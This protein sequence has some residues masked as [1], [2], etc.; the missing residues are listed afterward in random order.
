MKRRALVFG[1]LALLVLAPA[2][3]WLYR[4]AYLPR[5]RAEF[6]PWMRRLGEWRD[7]VETT[8][9]ALKRRD[10]SPDDPEGVVVVRQWAWSGLDRIAYV[11]YEVRRPTHEI[12]KSTD[13]T[14]GLVY[15]TVGGFRAD[16]ARIERSAA[17]TVTTGSPPTARLTR[18]MTESIERRPRFR[19]A[20]AVAGLGAGRRDP[21]QTG[22][23]RLIAG[24]WPGSGVAV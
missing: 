7:A 12:G 3:V 9:R 8:R 16:G 17:A 19:N 23:N 24:I 22:T 15:F 18:V 5:L 4:N 10:A 14:S 1:A 21:P 2:G 13:V 11:S 20:T 6:V